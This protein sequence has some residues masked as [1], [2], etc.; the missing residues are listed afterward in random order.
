MKRVL[1]RLTLPS[2]SM[3]E[4]AWVFHGVITPEKY[5]EDKL[6]CPKPT[7]LRGLSEYRDRLVC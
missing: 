1:P 5:Y 2:T 7:N 4:R 3:G 6:I